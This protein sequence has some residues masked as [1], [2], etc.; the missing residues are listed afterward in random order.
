MLTI[1]V[2]KSVMDLQG[3]SVCVCA[4]VLLKKDHACFFPPRRN[5]EN[6]PQIHSVMRFL[7]TRVE[8]LLPGGRLPSP[9]DEEEKVR[10]LSALRNSCC[11]WPSGLD[12]RGL[13][14]LVLISNDEHSA[15][16]LPFIWLPNRQQEHISRPWSVFTDACI[17]DYEAARCCR[18]VKTRL[19]SFITFK[20]SMP[21]FLNAFSFFFTRSHARCTECFLSGRSWW[22]F[23]PQLE[24]QI[25]RNLK[26]A[27]L[28]ESFS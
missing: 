10:L 9:W 24:N 14:C 7:N 11:G 16:A 5:L 1:D 20:R 19:A 18:T 27:S 25:Y 13:P 2:I 3:Y 6:T 17:N 22:P 21:V 28:S 12:Q 4:K 23:S 15:P 8:Q 26:M